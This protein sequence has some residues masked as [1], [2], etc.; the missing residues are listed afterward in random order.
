MIVKHSI[1]YNS[2]ILISL[3]QTISYKEGASDKR[4]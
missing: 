4:L 2:D 3:C 1:S